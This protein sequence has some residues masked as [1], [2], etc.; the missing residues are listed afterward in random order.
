MKNS[1]YLLFAIS[2]FFVFCFKISAVSITPNTSFF[3]WGNDQGS[4]SGGF[5]SGSVT[6]TTNRVDLYGYSHVSSADAYSQYIYGWNSTI[7]YTLNKDSNYVVTFRI[8]NTHML[9]GEITTARL[10]RYNLNNATASSGIQLFK[11]SYSNFVDSNVDS[12]SSAQ[13]DGGNA[14]YDVTFEFRATANLSSFTLGVYEPNK[15]PIGFYL[16]RNSVGF[17]IQSADILEDTSQTIIN[18]NQTQINQNNTIIDQNKDIINKQEET[19]K[20]LGELN[21]NITDDSVSDATDTANGFFD[22]FED[23][24]FGLSDIISI[25][26]NTINQITSNSCIEL[27]LNIPFVNKTLTLPCMNTIYKNYFGSFLTI[28]QTITFGIIAYWVCI[29]IYAMVKG[30]KDPNKDEIEVLDL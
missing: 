21:D 22:N 26:L 7:N 30:F 13:A 25:P 1:K 29:Q 8:L 27:S 24:D 14:T 23:N 10:S 6:S 2:L 5:N 20:E 4:S 16:H 15:Y 3:Y 18:Q 11:V 12:T 17:I 28:Y 9:T 19:N